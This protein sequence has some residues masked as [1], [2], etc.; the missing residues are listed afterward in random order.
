MVYI[1]DGICGVGCCLGWVMRASCKA[2]R[3]DNGWSAAGY[4]VP[5]NKPIPCNREIKC[6][7]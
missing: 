4:D 3:N 7:L 6:C 1:F 5:T 2:D